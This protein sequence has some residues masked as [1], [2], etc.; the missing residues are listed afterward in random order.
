MTIIL[1]SKVLRVVCI[2]VAAGLPLS[3]YC[4]DLT[5]QQQALKD[6][7]EFADGICTRV[8]LVG[9]T[10]K[11][12]LSGQAKAEL[13][14]IVKK[15]ANLGMSGAANYKNE[16]SQNVLQADLADTIKHSDDCRQ[17]IA[18][19]LID[20]LITTP[21]ASRLNPQTCRDKSHGVESY[22]RTFDTERSS[23][24]MGGGFTQPQW[25]AQA[26]ATLR[27]EHPEGG[28]EVVTSS[29]R[30]QNT[31]PPFNCPQYMYSCT[32][33]VKTDPVYIE[34]ASRACH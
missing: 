20:K 26:I 30:T 27:G 14:G 34:K 5:P 13:T 29:E 23:S 19:K 32:V 8:P 1:T 6:I 22:A 31:C 12:E 24:W 2:T 7:Q 10:T 18:E 11:V 16:E 28:F 17:R 33:R 4:A 25:C 15:L 3:T 9:T 21:T